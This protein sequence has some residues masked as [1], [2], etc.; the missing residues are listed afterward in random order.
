MISCYKWEYLLTSYEII[1]CRVA[2]SGNVVVDVDIKLQGVMNCINQHRTFYRW[3]LL[4]EREDMVTCAPGSFF[5]VFTAV[6][7]IP[8]G[9]TQ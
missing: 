7:A 3:S 9:A 1:F 4:H 2:K 8:C 5:R 6:P